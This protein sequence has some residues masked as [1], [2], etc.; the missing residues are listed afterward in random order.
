MNRL[1]P[2]ERRRVYLARQRA[3]QRML[4]RLNAL[5]T[6]AVDAGADERGRRRLLKAVAIAAM[7]GGSFLVS[8]T[9]S[10]TRRLR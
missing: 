8:Q 1:T 10:T 9:S 3:R 6:A 4:V 5:P 7:L 2:Q